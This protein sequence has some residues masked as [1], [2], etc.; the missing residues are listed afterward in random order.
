MSDK[1]DVLPYPIQPSDEPGA[2]RLAIAY[3]IVRR[4]GRPETDPTAVARLVGEVIRIMIE[5]ERG[6]RD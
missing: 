5:A 3:D 2:T 6:R 1:H 4:Y